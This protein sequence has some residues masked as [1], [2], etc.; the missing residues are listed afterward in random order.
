[1]HVVRAR[2]LRSVRPWSQDVARV[3]RSE[4][5]EDVEVDGGPRVSLALYPG[6]GLRILRLRS[7]LLKQFNLI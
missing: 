5:R 3:E 6:Y 2:D 4:T 7:E 1:M